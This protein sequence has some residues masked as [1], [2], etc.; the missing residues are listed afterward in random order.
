MCD[1]DAEQPLCRSSPEQGEKQGLCRQPDQIQ[2][3]T[4]DDRVLYCL[5]EAR[6]LFGHRRAESNYQKKE[7]RESRSADVNRA[8]KQ[9]PPRVMLPAK[10][11]LALINGCAVDS[12]A[13]SLGAGDGALGSS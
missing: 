11:G 10:K 2:H 8:R 9:P 3:D 5:C 7:Q 12:R 1:P 4:G 6:C 13:M